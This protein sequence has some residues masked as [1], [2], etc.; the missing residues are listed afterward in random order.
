MILGAMEGKNIR[1]NVKSEDFR[2]ETFFVQ[3]SNMENITARAGTENQR[4]RI[5]FLVSLHN[6]HIGW[7][8][9]LYT[10]LS[11]QLVVME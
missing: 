10:Y 5:I 6:F 3:G 8:L 2:L 7:I 1:E 9:I 4:S 11:C